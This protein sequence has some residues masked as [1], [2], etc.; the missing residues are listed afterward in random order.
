MLRGLSKSILEKFPI[1]LIWDY[2]G[3]AL[4]QFLIWLEN[5]RHPLNQSNPKL[6]PITSW[7]PASSRALVSWL[8]LLF[9]KFSLD[10]KSYAQASDRP[11]L[12]LWF[13]FYDTQSKSTLSVYS[14]TICLH[15]VYTGGILPLCQR[16]R[17]WCGE[18]QASGDCEEK[19][20]RGVET[21]PSQVWSGVHR[22]QRQSKNFEVL[23]L[24]HLW[25][26]GLQWVTPS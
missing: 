14:L 22:Y 25:W 8:F 13:W 11:L 9:T 6:K 18:I 10:L 21:W 4:L 16:R 24:W 17:L 19:R 7:S 5:S 2:I 23:Q 26:W 15:V 12:L 20:R 1:E 3:F